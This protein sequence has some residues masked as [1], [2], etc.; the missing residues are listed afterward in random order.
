MDGRFIPAP[1]K[2]NNVNSRVESTKNSNKNTHNLQKTATPHKSPHKWGNTAMNF[3]LPL[4][5]N[6]SNKPTTE[7]NKNFNTKSTLTTFHNKEKLKKGYS[8]NIVNHN[9]F[10]SKGVNFE[11]TTTSFKTTNP[12]ESIP[13]TAIQTKTGNF[14]NLEHQRKVSDRNKKVRNSSKQSFFKPFVRRFLPSLSKSIKE[15]NP[16]EINSSFQAVKK[17]K[18]KEEFNLPILGKDKIEEILD[19]VVNSRKQIRDEYAKITP[20]CVRE[21]KSNIIKEWKSITNRLFNIDVR[22]SLL[23]IK[24]L[25]DIHIEFDEYDKAK[26]Y[27]S[28]FKFLATNL[29]L[30][31]ELMLAYESLGIVSKY[32]YK[33][34]K[35]IQYFKK[36]IEVAW[37]LDDKVSELRAY[38]HIGIQYFYLA[39]KQRARYYHY[40]F[41]CGRYEKETELK[42]RVKSD[43]MQ[44][45][46]N[47]FDNEQYKNRNFDIDKNKQK[48]KE[49]LNMFDNKAQLQNNTEIDLNQVPESVNI[50]N[51]SKSNITFNIISKL[52][53]YYIC[54]QRAL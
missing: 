31:E 48:M 19:D 34:H 5:K 47:F 28:Y 36:Q 42:K 2:L 26:S 32:L 37:I 51:V 21:Y 17:E 25:G 11:G 45:N 12:K 16:S 15:S 33:H 22:L 27:Y 8:Q 6:K 29:E 10:S 44:K 14:F 54:S 7:L 13:S 35:A 4:S 53:L 38:D 39:N 18:E 23:G 43:F 30:L 52:R 24:I 46:F 40:R 3:K 41:I 9:K 49:L 50:S 20:K 1:L